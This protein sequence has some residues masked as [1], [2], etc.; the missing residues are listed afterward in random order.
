MTGDHSQPVRPIKTIYDISWEWMIDSESAVV[1][2]LARVMAF[3]V[4][5]GLFTCGEDVLFLEGFILG[6]KE[7]S[8]L[9]IFLSSPFSIL[10]FYTVAF[11]VTLASK[12]PAS[13][14]DVFVVWHGAGGAFGLL[15]RHFGLMRELKCVDSDDGFY[16]SRCKVL[17]GGIEEMMSVDGEL[18]KRSSP[19][20]CIFIGSPMS[21]STLNRKAEL[22]LNECSVSVLIVY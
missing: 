10:P 22:L 2:L 7:R 17:S 6:I 4:L 19:W 9:L 18:P 5:R 11:S 8:S 20:T 3:L 16:D 13:G 1:D 12:W 21:C 14:L 15:G